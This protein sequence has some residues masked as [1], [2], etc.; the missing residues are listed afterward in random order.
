VVD[1]GYVADPLAS[2]V[3]GPKMSGSRGG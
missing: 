1:P 2:R 3:P